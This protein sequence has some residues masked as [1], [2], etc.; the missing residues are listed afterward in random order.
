MERKRKQ[1]NAEQKPSSLRGASVESWPFSRR[2]WLETCILS[3][4]ACC[5]L[6]LLVLG[7]LLLLK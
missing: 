6:G 2:F 5:M 7:D 3:L 4:A 1:Q